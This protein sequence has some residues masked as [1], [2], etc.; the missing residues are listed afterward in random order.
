MVAASF[1]RLRPRSALI[2]ASRTWNR[3][4]SRNC[5][6]ADRLDNVIRV[7]PNCHRRAHYAHDRLNI[8]ARM[9]WRHYFDA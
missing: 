7:C 2:A 8:K 9:R 3:I 1:A 5:E 4:T 6:G